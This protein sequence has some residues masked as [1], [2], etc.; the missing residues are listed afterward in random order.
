MREKS[1]LA[2]SKTIEIIWKVKPNFKYLNNYDWC[3]LR[4]IALEKDGLL[5]LQAGSE[6][7]ILNKFQRKLRIFF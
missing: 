2:Y 1:I 5:F 4:N 3:K 7:T 6:N